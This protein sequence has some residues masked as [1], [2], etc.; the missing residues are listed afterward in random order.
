L[1]VA[2]AG[3]AFIDQWLEWRHLFYIS[4]SRRI[5]DILKVRSSH[6]K[7]LIVTETQPKDFEARSKT[8]KRKKIPFCFKEKSFSAT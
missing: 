3:C 8:K 1:C 4:T 7:E 2:A 6:W 5:Y